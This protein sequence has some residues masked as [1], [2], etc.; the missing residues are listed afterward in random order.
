MLGTGLLLSVSFGGAWSKKCTFFPSGVDV[1]SPGL[2]LAGFRCWI[3][4]EGLVGR[5]WMFPGSQTF[6]LFSAP[7]GHLP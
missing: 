2:L 6:D 5:F 7:F 1:L 3:T 4:P